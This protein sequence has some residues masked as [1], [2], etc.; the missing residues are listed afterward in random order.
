MA[1]GVAFT[2]AVLVTLF[3]NILHPSA[4]FF[5]PSGDLLPLQ[6]LVVALPPAC[7][8]RCH[9]WLYCPVHQHHCSLQLHQRLLLVLPLYFAC[10]IHF[11]LQNLSFC[12]FLKSDCVNSFFRLSLQ[13]MFEGQRS[14]LGL[15]A[16]GGTSTTDQ[17]LRRKRL[18]RHALVQGDGCAWAHPPQGHARVGFVQVYNAWRNLCVWLAYFE[19]LLL[20]LLHFICTY[21]LCFTM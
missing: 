12:M 20:P 4:D 6:D 5:L 19:G 15:E 21:F 1:S 17:R 11:A 7:G 18:V 16:P 14:G 2:A 13:A 3:T 10:F 8:S 9:L